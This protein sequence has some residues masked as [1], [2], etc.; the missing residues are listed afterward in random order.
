MVVP[1]PIRE[2][3]SISSTSRRTPGNP[4]PRLGTLLVEKPGCIAIFT[5][6][7][8]GPASANINST[9]TH[10]VSLNCVHRMLPCPAYC[11]TL[12]ASSEAA[13]T[14]RVVSVK[15]NPACAAAS[16]TNFRA[17]IRSSSLQICIS[18]RM[19]PAYPANG[20]VKWYQSSPACRAPD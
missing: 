18:K 12:R 16:R 9:P 19:H 10:C 2:V 6:A 14:K 13:V 1:C 15:S 3:M 5:S 11:K 8:P 17:A 7:I 4:N 20:P